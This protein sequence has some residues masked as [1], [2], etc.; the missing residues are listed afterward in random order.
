MTG[1]KKVISDLRTRG[2]RTTPIRLSIISILQRSTA[3]LSTQQLL[4]T[5]SGHPHKTTVYRETET[6]ARAGLLR[7]IDIGDGIKRYESTT[8]E[9]H[10][11]VICTSCR[12]IKEIPASSCLQ[13]LRSARRIGFSV[14]DHDVQIFGLCANCK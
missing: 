8:R 11:H 1:N 7:S 9:H 2:M 6:L 5:L 3:P 10:H 13:E 12:S 4:A 14:Q